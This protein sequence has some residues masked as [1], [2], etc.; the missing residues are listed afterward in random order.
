MYHIY[1]DAEFDAVRI[2][3]K[4]QQSVISIGAVIADPNMQI[5]D[6]FYMLVRPEKFK[7]LTSVVRRMTHLKH[8]DILN[9]A[10]FSEMLASFFSWIQQYC[11]LEDVVTYS[12]G[13]DDRRTLVQNCTLCDVDDRGLF[14]NVKD[15]QKVI[16]ADI[17]YRDVIISPTLSL[18]DVKYVYDLGDS[19]DHNALMDARDLMMVHNAFMKHQPQN[20]AHI[21][22][23]MERKQQKQQEA[24]L[25]QQEKLKKMMTER[26]Q[27]YPQN[28]IRL[29]FYPEIIELMQTWKERDRYFHLHI[30]D[31]MLL[32][33]G[34]AYDIN[35]THISL[36][37]CLTQEMPSISFH[38]HLHD[39]V[40]DKKYMLTYRNATMVEAI[41]KRLLGEWNEG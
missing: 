1:L 8:S 13:P 40:L 18:D 11:R 26:F 28:D 30:R 3:G 37:L 39:I 9:A 25:R 27:H 41:Y 16:S 15:V 22:E 10:P 20:K 14:A 23:I 19:V 5:I 4:F 31:D 32:D 6:D 12:F 34:V 24:R 7:R 17:L 35:N 29:Y 2:K 21:E 38:I 33:D 36:S